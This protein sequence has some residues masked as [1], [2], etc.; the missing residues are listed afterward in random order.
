LPR[1]RRSRIWNQPYPETIRM[2][3]WTHDEEDEVVFGVMRFA[4]VVKV[5]GL[6]SEGIVE[7]SSGF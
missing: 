3:Q 5:D 6:L 7:P 1:R 2:D 4:L